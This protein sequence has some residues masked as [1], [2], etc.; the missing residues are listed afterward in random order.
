MAQVWLIIIFP[1]LANI[2]Q[3]RS[4]RWYMF[5]L[6]TVTTLHYF[7]LGIKSNILYHIYAFVMRIH[8]PIAKK[9]IKTKQHSL[10]R[11]WF[12]KDNKLNLNNMLYLL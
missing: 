10:V 8:S 6:K 1:V 3:D 5:L 12:A 4:N 11:F 7:T 9:A 2:T